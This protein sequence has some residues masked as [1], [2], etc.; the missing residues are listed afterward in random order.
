MSDLTAPQFPACRQ[1]VSDQ[2]S[3]DTLTV[4]EHHNRPRHPILA[5]LG[6]TTGPSPMGLARRH[7]IHMACVEQHER[8]LD[9]HQIIRFLQWR[10]QTLHEQNAD[11][12]EEIRLI[13][14]EIARSSPHS[15][16]K[17][18]PAAALVREAVERPNPRSSPE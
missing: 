13:R 17:H 1:P 15:Y 14:Q 2:E 12:K 18:I 11:M 7:R 4:W 10:V 6:V 9:D 5:A 8:N 16:P 3:V